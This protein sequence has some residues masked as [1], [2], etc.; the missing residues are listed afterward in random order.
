M[1]ILSKKANFYTFKTFPLSLWIF[2]GICLLFAIYVNYYLYC[3]ARR[4]ESL[5]L[6]YVMMFL[7]YLISFITLYAGKI[8]Y[9]YIDKKKGIIRKRLINIFLSKI[10]IVKYINNL[11]D[12]KMVLRGTKTYGNENSCYFIR[13]LFKDGSK[14]EFGRT[15]S[16]YEIQKKYR[17]SKAILHNEIIKDMAKSYLVVNEL[18]D[19][20][21]Y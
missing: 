18:D 4:H 8:E 1:K 14:I 15:F 6:I 2:S 19:T 9:L 11:D 12:I 3:V 5:P 21:L 7:F 20:T 16:Y 17:I 10:E 13:Y